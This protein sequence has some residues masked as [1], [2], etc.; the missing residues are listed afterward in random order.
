ERG[1]ETFVGIAAHRLF[2]ASLSN[3]VQARRA[4]GLFVSG[5]YFSLLGLKPALGR[6]LGPQDD[7]VDGQAESVVLSYAYWHSELGGDPDLVGRRLIVSGAPLTI[8]GV[9][10]RGFHG[11]TVGVRA[12]V[13]VP[14]TFRGLGAFG[15]V[16]DHD[17][18]LF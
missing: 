16:P 8:V 7:R 12:S 14:I 9:A 5:N 6:L 1:Q 15:S 17:N 13:F 18:R 2:A 10:P 11:T 3:G 4:D